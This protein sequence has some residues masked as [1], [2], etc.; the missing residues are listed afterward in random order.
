MMTS[1]RNDDVNNIFHGRTG[2]VLAIAVGTAVKV[3]ISSYK[4]AQKG[5]AVSINP[6]LA[7]RARE[8]RRLGIVVC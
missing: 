6:T 8:E 3:L 1:S 4:R 5:C 7:W 2:E